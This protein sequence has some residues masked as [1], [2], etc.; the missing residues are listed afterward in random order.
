MSNNSTGESSEIRKR[1]SGYVYNR[2]SSPL[3]HGRKPSRR[4]SP[5]TRPQYHY[6]PPSHQISTFIPRYPVT[7]NPVKTSNFVD[8][9]SS[10]P[11]F[12]SQ[13]DVPF[14]TNGAIYLPPKNQKLPSHAQSET[15]ANYRHRTHQNLV[16]E[17]NPHQ[18]SDAT[19]FLTQ[20][21]QAISQLYGAPALNENYAPYAPD[22]DPN[23]QAEQLDNEFPQTERVQ[24]SQDFQDFA[25]I[26]NRE[27]LQ[28]LEKDRLIYQLQ[29]ALLRNIETTPQNAELKSQD[30]LGR[31]DVF[32]PD[33]GY[34]FSTTPQTP[35]DVSPNPEGP[36][37][38][39]Y[40]GFV[41]IFGGEKPTE[42]T[43]T[44]FV[45]PIPGFQKAA[46]EPF[47]PAYPGPAIHRVVNPVYQSS[48]INKPIT[49]VHPLYYQTNLAIQELK[50]AALSNPWSYAN[51]YTAGKRVGKWKA[52]IVLVLRDL[53]ICMDFIYW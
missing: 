9:H 3:H 8:S 23:S 22:T 53:Y 29:K 14:T 27:S 18:I 52:F 11:S 19:L 21:A 43:P 51:T 31:P 32:G 34:G 50:H 10:V 26:Q 30:L 48:V 44:H 4:P 40:G 5:L 39:H 13:N 33:F 42:Q 45:I 24:S 28:S 6:G 36:D 2:P 37:F 41:P 20:N 12:T 38:S 15:F 46:F 35:T 7:P 1:E 16:Q 17:T 25:S 47:A 49:G